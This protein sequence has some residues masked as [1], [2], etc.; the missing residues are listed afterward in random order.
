MIRLNINT[1]QALFLSVIVSELFSYTCNFNFIP[2]NYE[3][4]ETSKTTAYCNSYLIIWLWD[5]D[6][7]QQLAAALWP[8]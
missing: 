7:Q 5:L 8:F 4:L 2:Y 3:D 1:L 6:L